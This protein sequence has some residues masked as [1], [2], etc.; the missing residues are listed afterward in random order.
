M[1][2]E[3]ALHDSYIIREVVRPARLVIVSGRSNYRST[4]GYQHSGRLAQG[5]R[6]HD[7]RGMDP[8]RYSGVFT[9]S[10]DVLGGALVEAATCAGLLCCTYRASLPDL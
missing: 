4:A 2:S 9:R 8:Q 5:K 3:N 1:L 7:E 10:G 6:D